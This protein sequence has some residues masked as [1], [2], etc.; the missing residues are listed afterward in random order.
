MTRRGHAL[1]LLAAAL[2]AVVGPR[3]VPAGEGRYA[4]VPPGLDAVVGSASDEALAAAAASMDAG[5]DG[6]PDAA[7]YPAARS[8]LVLLGDVGLKHA[9]RRL[10]RG[11]V[12]RAAMTHLLTVV[13]SGEHPDA[14]VLLERAAG[15]PDAEWRMIAADGL[16]R[17]RSP[18]AVPALAALAKDPVPGVRVAAL[19]SLFAIEGP[20]AVAARRDVPADPRPDLLAR[21]LAWH[22]S[23][24][25][26]SPEVLALAASAYRRGATPALRVEAA[27]LLALPALEAPLPLLR[28]VVTEFGTGPV[29]AAL[30]R[31]ANGAPREGYAPGAAR[32]AAIEAALAALSRPDLPAPERAWVLDLAVGWTAHP[33]VLDAT[34]KEPIPEL[35]LHARLP[36]FGDAIVPHVLARLRPGGFETPSVGVELIRE[37]GGL[38]SLPALR[39]L[40]GP[41][42]PGS[43]RAAASG[44]IRDLGAVGDEALARAVLAGDSSRAIR[45]DVLRALRSEPGAWA[46]RLLGETL[47]SD[48][49]GMASAAA[50]ALEERRE[51][52]A[53]DLLVAHVLS[54]RDPQ[55]ER[56]LRHLVESFDAEAFALLE[57]VLR[58]GK[59]SLRAA[60]LDPFS[61]VPPGRVEGAL[62][63]LRPFA[64]RARGALEVQAFVTALLGV[65]PEEAVR[66]VRDRWDALPVA[67]VPAM[68]R[69]L[70]SRLGSATGEAAVRATI[71]LALEKTRARDDAALLSAA[72]G[73]LKDRA[74]WRDAELDAFWLR[75][76]RHPDEGLPWTAA[77]YL[78]R[79]GRGDLTAGL[80]PLLDRTVRDLEHPE[81]GVFV[82]RAL[83]HQPWAKAEP[84][85]LAAALERDAPTDV[86]A[87]A[88]WALAGRCSPASRAALE[89]WLLESGRDLGEPALG[90]AV[91]AAVGEGGGPE[92][93]AALFEAIRGELFAHYSTPESLDPRALRLDGLGERLAVLAQAVAYTRDEPAMDR[94]VDLVFDAR[95]AAYARIAM[96]LKAMRLPEAG[97]AEAG[98]RTAWPRDLLSGGPPRETGALEFAM[99]SEVWMLAGAVK[100]MGD[101]ALAR[102]LERVVGEARATGRLALF[103][104][105]YLF[106]AV[107]ALRDKPTREMDAAADVVERALARVEPV[108]G[109]VDQAVLRGRAWRLPFRGRYADA[110]RAQEGIVRIAARRGYEDEF[111]GLYA[112][113]RATLDALRGADFASRGLEDQARDAFRR[114]LARAPHDPVVLQ[115]CAWYRAL[116]DFDLDVAESEAR[117]ARTLER[118]TDG[119]PSLDATDTL[120]FVLLRRSR[121]GAAAAMLK[122]ALDRT[123]RPRDGIYH[124]HLAE[125]WAQSGYAEGAAEALLDALEREPA[126]ADVAREDPYLEPLRESGRLEGLIAAAEE[127]ARSSE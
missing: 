17:G 101:A 98:G 15:E 34:A 49:T 24:G 111:A 33:V 93:A 25:D 7:S 10:A 47:A 58:E 119:E 97:P 27:R 94:M 86:R 80:L 70:L 106:R 92:V 95:F 118:R 50:D 9:A 120:A 48:D 121:P 19:R 117:R 8:L 82:I 63:V 1:P 83:R 103:P 59:P 65:A 12:P 44:G 22:R 40:L 107:S 32:T 54:G 126:L 64:A 88:A 31:F 42:R 96:R 39:E 18:R 66:W 60:A 30:V 11:D 76:L 56:R 108:D 100:P 45:T 2:L 5:P 37:A 62:A 36:D 105:L 51:P 6:R 90:L 109:A 16:G 29:G 35:L 99:P 68:Q 114:A 89:R 73:A 110:A 123:P 67:D 4:P 43:I 72:C 20:E 69:T 87:A 28:T 74:G 75:A 13:A 77:Q 91:A 46:V 26:A 84:A 113:E 71:D 115:T 116:V 125:A 102:S 55:P 41:E 53:R 112:R 122:Y 21:R 3:A 127:R 79:P 81:R 61:F 85:V 57:R 38:R 78:D 124:F 14:D 104:D 23:R 52:E